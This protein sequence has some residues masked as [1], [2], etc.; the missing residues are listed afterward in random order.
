MKNPP[1]S[2]PATITGGLELT[3]VLTLVLSLPLLFVMGA[4][5]RAAPYF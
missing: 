4:A 1:D 3:L 2:L 5:D